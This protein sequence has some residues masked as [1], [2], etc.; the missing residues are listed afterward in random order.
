MMPKFKNDTLTEKIIACCFKVH[1]ELGAGFPERIYHNALADCLAESEFK[2][3]SEKEFNVF[4]NKKK[5]GTFR[6]DLLVN[7]KVII[8]IKAVSGKTPII[9][10]YQLLSYL[11]A[12]GIKT[13]L[14]VN[15]GNKS[16]ELRRLNM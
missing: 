6:C 8:E 12:S 16:C 14:L 2:V 15:F 13:G 7:D 9:F 5:V 10:E 3:I 11:K 4:F 1:T